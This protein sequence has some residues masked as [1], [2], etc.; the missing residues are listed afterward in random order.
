[1]NARLTAQF[2]EA[3][4]DDGIDPAMT[5]AQHALLTAL[6]PALIWVDDDDPDTS[7]TRVRDIDYLEFLAAEDSLLPDEIWWVAIGPMR[8]AL[9][10][11][12]PPCD[13]CRATPA[14]YDAAVPHLQG[15]WANLCESC[16]ATHCPPA[17]G[18]GVGQRLE[19]YDSTP[20]WVS[21]MCDACR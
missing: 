16:W 14:H 17:L 19:T 20:E 1:M 21:R 3:L 7:D 15:R 8:L 11:E 5:K 2:L 10:D 13:L 9:M 6:M 12:L 4:R 18:G